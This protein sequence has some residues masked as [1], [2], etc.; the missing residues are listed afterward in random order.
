MVKVGLLVLLGGAASGQL[1]VVSHR[2]VLTPRAFVS[3][4]QWGGVLPTPQEIAG[5]IQT[6]SF[7][8][9]YQKV[10][11]VTNENTQYQL[12]LALQRH[13]LLLRDAELNRMSFSGETLGAGVCANIVLTIGGLPY[14]VNVGLKVT[15][16][17]PKSSDIAAKIINRHVKIAWQRDKEADAPNTAAVINNALVEANLNTGLTQADMQ[18]V[19]FLG[20]LDAATVIQTVRIRMMIESDGDSPCFGYLFVRMEPKSAKDIINSIQLDQFKVRVN[21]PD[22]ESEGTMHALR[23]RLKFLNPTLE[24]GDLTKLSFRGILVDH[25]N[26]S[27]AVTATVDTAVE[28]KMLTVWK[29]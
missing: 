1:T 3:A 14:A 18:H 20:R 9:A 21:D 10:S 16:R 19:S 25:Q 29:L 26:V 22:T 6:R 4:V 13:N 27:I 7:E 12:G 24:A 15:M 2:Q 17:Y 11:D 23:R 28:S 5:K 8:I